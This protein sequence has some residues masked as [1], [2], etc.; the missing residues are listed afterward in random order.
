MTFFKKILQIIDMVINYGISPITI[1]RNRSCLK[2][3]GPEE[4]VE[5]KDEHG[6]GPS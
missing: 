3:P 6:V 4:G 2:L 5:N 1:I